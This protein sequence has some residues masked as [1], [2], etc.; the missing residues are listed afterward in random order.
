[1]DTSVPGSLR[2]LDGVGQDSHSPHTTYEYF[3]DIIP[4]I[5]S[6]PELVQTK[7]YQMTAHMHHFEGPP[8]QM[9]AVYVRYQ[10]SPITV[11]FKQRYKQFSHF[12][13]YVCAIVGGVFTVA[14]LL[15]SIL[16]S[17]VIAFQ[18]NVLGKSS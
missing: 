3:L 12:L 11:M 15:N 16:Q 4:S 10:L 5:Y 6:N 9:P 13:T 18:K 1:M 14:G 2:P 8:N 7:S 17:S